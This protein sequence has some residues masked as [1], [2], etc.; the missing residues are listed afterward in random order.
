MV[1]L[2]CKIC[3]KKFEVKEFDAGWRKYCNSEKC[4]NEVRRLAMQRYRQTDRGKA[5]VKLQNMRYKRAEREQECYVCK[6]KFM[7]ARK[8]IACDGCIARL[9]SKG[10]V[11]PERAL[12]MRKWRIRNKDR[13]KVYTKSQIRADRPSKKRPRQPCLVCNNPKTDQHHHDYNKALDVSFLCKKH[14]FE[15]HSWDSFN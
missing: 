3:G 13:V 10:V 12:S 7:S 8:R 2:N 15:L 4:N 5:M 1:N 14:H 9:T 6:N 11:E